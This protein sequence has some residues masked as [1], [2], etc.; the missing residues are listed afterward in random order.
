MNV[1]VPLT[2]LPSSNKDG[3]MAP[4]VVTFRNPHSFE[5]LNIPYNKEIKIVIAVLTDKKKKKKTNRM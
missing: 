2:R 5:E 4:V 3:V 1:K